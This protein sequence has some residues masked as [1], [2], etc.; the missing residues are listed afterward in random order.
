M[1]QELS[2]KEY[3]QM[4]KEAGESLKQN[5]NWDKLAQK[6]KIAV[7]LGSGLGVFTDQLTN[8]IE[9][10]YANVKNMP[11]SSVIGHDGQWVYGLAN[12]VPVLVAK[13]RSHYY[14]GHDLKIVTLPIR[15]LKQLGIENL[16]LTNAAG[17]VNLSFHPGD[18][19]LIED[20]INIM[21]ATPLMGINDDFF[22]PRFVDMSEAYGKA[23][24]EKLQ[25]TWQK[26]HP[27]VRLHQGVYFWYTGPQY[28]TPAEI[29]LAGKLGAD[30]VGMSTVPEC[31]VARQAGIKV[32]GI[33][34]ITNYGSGIGKHN[35]SHDD[36]AAM[37]KKR[38]P[39]FCNLV[40]EM[41]HTISS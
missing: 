24:N 33:T 9:V 7:V 22:G 29:K 16:I 37:A 35:L 27:D 36:V 28:E 13:G 23:V 6:P 25:A 21:G 15:I 41:I 11:V 20:H 3:I 12:G 17:S 2:S 5:L 8:K 34:C 1:K 31:L 32:N 4:I 39:D 10:P 14:E 30:A 26:K 18:F 38:A 40:T 19:M